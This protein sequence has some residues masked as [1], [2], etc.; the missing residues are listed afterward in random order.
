MPRAAGAEAAF[1]AGKG[2]GAIGKKI[3]KATGAPHLVEVGMK[4]CH[5]CAKMAPVIRDIL[6]KCGASA[7]SLLEHVDVTDPEGEEIGRRYGVTK[8]P[9][10]LAVDAK[11]AEVSRL[12][13]VQKAG[14]IAQLVGEVTGRACA[15][16]EE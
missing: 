5:A 12:V 1:G 14:A 10:I 11:G 15:A 8:L 6:S 9:T 7:A 2:D 13:G 16:P 3:G 4:G